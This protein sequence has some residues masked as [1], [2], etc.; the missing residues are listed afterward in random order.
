[1]KAAAFI[2]VVQLPTA[3]QLG[4]FVYLD[5]HT[6]SLHNAAFMTRH[7]QKRKTRAPQSHT[8]CP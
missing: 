3:A 4:Q 8:W 6:L 1:M 2:L 7:T 5:A